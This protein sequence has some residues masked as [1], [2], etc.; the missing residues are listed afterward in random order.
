MLLFL[1][2]CIIAGWRDANKWSWWV[3]GSI[4][5]FLSA[6]LFSWI[7][8]LIVA[9]L[10]VFGIHKRITLINWPFTVSYPCMLEFVYK[11]GF[12]LVWKNGTT[13]KVKFHKKK[14]QEWANRNIFTE[15]PLFVR[16]IFCWVYFDLTG[17]HM[18]TYCKVGSYPEL[19]QTS[20][21]DCLMFRKTIH[22]RCFTEFYIQLFV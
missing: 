20:N 11:L 17:G 8:L 18:N 22:L 3:D 2:W 7:L 5:F 16:M 12:P 15:C 9:I 4:S 13:L 21:M 14:H 10:L 6:A 1:T 19:C